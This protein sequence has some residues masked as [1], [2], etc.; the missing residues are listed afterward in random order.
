MDAGRGS[1]GAV[2]PRRATLEEVAAGAVRDQLVPLPE[3]EID[4]GTA[5]A[6]EDLV[7][8]YLRAGAG[9]AIPDDAFDV[10]KWIFLEYLAR[11]GRFL[12]HGSTRRGLDRL[13]P[14]VC[15][16]NIEG[17]QQPRVYAS[18][19][20]LLA[21]F[22][23]IYDRHRAASWGG[24]GRSSVLNLPEGGGADPW[25]QRV[26][27]AVDHRLLP[28]FPWTTGCVY[29]LPASAFLPD[30]LGIRWHSAG[31]V[32]PLARV[33]MAAHEW[34]L[35]EYVRGANIG[36]SIGRFN[37]RATGYPWWGEREIYPGRPA[38]DRARRVRAFI[39]EHYALRLPLEELAGLV[40]LSPCH[41]LRLFRATTGLTPAGYQLH[42]RVERARLLL[43]S[44]LA[45]AGVAT[46]TGFADQSHMTRVFRRIVGVTPGRFASD[47]KNRQDARFASR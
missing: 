46:M 19:S 15:S 9:G 30:L 26:H 21:I 39:D 23:A 29:I 20:G 22:H 13:E 31:P 34:P 2:K 38:H 3:I 35:L 43:A 27:V 28:S 4:E 6:C 5:A 41:L 25:R 44:G 12:F 33:A 40:E 8:V 14:R 18:A 7:R 11:R 16:D 47:R 1:F 36:A 10:P 17:S 24:P 42:R 45:I 37:D 32:R